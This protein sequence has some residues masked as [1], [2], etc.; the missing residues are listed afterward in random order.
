MFERIR[1]DVRCVFERDPAARS[2]FDVLTTYPGIHALLMH[3][4][5]HWLW[6]LGLQW[7]ARVFSNIARWYTGIE[8]HPAA[9][10]GRRF[11]IDHGMGVVIGETTEIGDDCTLYHGVTL[12]GTSWD[13]GKRHP[14]LG[15]NVVIG[16][17]AKVLGPILVQDGVRIGSNAVVLKDVAAD[18]TV[19]GVPGRLVSGHHEADEKRQAIARKMG[20]DAYG[21]TRDMPDPVATAVN[22]ILD[23]IHIMDQRLE[24]MCKGL[25]DLGAEVG[26]LN[27]PDLGPCA[28]KHVDDGEIETAVA[29]P[30]KQAEPESDA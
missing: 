13:K 8:I 27:L 22:G 5:S 2:T 4:F 11:F 26:D 18:M 9:T 29:T 21:A 17:G 14:T 19:V 10:I 23:H 6:S 16:A 12:G 1:E 25:K 15:N 28:L 7:L 30:E 3:R 20:F 24:D